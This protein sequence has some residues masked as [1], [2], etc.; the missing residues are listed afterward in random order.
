M[1]SHLTDEIEA[2]IESSPEFVFEMINYYG[3][4]AFSRGFTRASAE[5]RR[6]YPEEDFIIPSRAEIAKAVIDAYKTP[7]KRNGLGE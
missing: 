4:D 6:I 1:N 7:E 3:V 5:Y 2:M